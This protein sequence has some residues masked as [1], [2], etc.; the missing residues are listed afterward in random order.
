MAAF[1][2][3]LELAATTVHIISSSPKQLDARAEER[4]GKWS[5]RLGDAYKHASKFEDAAFFLDFGNICAA[6]GWLLAFKV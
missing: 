5:M 6:C 1:R 4:D 3:G 2:W